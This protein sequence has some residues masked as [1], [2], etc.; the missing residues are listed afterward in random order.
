LQYSKSEQSKHDQQVSSQ[1]NEANAYGLSHLHRTEM[2]DP[3]FSLRVVIQRMHDRKKPT[4]F[5]RHPG[6]V[7]SSESP[8]FLLQE[9]GSSLGMATCTASSRDSTQEQDHDAPIHKRCSNA[10]S[11]TLAQNFSIVQPE[12][13]RRRYRR[14]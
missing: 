11:G 1:H 2:L 3:H 10:Y 5:L 9:F 8:H 12:P 7:Q 4:L 14:P 13:L 6:R